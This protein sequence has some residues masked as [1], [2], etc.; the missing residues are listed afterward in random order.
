MSNCEDFYETEETDSIISYG[1]LYEYA[2]D[3]ATYIYVLFEDKS[4]F[5]KKVC[6]VGQ[7]INPAQ[8]LIQHTVAPGNIEKVAWVGGLLNEKKH[9]K[10]CIID[11]IPIQDSIKIEKTYIHYFG[12]SLFRVGNGCQPMSPL[13]P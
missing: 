10:M 5:T 12:S 1:D 3:G 2:P 7:S 11:C 4:E 6:Y 8:R 13:V 9:P